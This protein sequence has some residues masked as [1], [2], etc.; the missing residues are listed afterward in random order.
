MEY[1][2]L[3]K[4]G[5]GAFGHLILVRSKNND[6]IYACKIEKNHGKV[7]VSNIVEIC[8]GGKGI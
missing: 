7:H 8:T 6:Q 3:E 4:I 5:S 2:C 1:E